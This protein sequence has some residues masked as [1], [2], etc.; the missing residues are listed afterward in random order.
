MIFSCCIY[1]SFHGNLFPLAWIWFVTTSMS[2]VITVYSSQHS[3]TRNFLKAHFLVPPWLPQQL[4]SAIIWHG[5]QVTHSC[6]TTFFCVATPFFPWC[7][8]FTCSTYLSL[9]GQGLR[10]TKTFHSPHVSYHYMCLHNPMPHCDSCA[11]APILTFRGLTCSNDF[12]HTLDQSQQPNV[13]LF[14]NL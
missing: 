1:S 4:L 9:V 8:I 13:Q 3:V 14:P 6:A 5:P 11:L 12:Q 7:Q 2:T 10:S